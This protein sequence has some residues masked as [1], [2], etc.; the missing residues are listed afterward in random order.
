MRNDE[1]KLC[2]LDR[3][4][5]DHDLMDRAT[6]KERIEVVQRWMREGKIKRVATR[7]RGREGGG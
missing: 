5:I 6:P 4:T 2:G 7:V 1:N 3:A